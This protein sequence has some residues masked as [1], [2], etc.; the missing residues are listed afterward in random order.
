LLGY[1]VHRRRNEDWLHIGIGLLIASLVAIRLLIFPLV[2][3]AIMIAMPMMLA[4][5]ISER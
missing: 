2:S 3:I 1:I 5:T 4:A